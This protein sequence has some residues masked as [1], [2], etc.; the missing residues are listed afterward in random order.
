MPLPATV[1]AFIAQYLLVAPAV[2]TAWAI[3]RRRKWIADLAEAALAGIV[4]IAIVKTGGALFAH[5]RP[6]VVYGRSPLLPHAPDNAFPSDHLAACGLAFAYLWPRSAPLAYVTLG[7][8]GLI[9][10]ARVL[11]LLHWPIDVAAGFVFGAC[12]AAAAGLAFR[13]MRRPQQSNP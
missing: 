7:C 3:F 9:A 6:F 10:A 12:G 1:V 5:A 2:L 11:A 13:S 4:T 8:A